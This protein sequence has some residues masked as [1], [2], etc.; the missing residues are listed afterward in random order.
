MANV[1]A[2]PNAIQTLADV[3]SRWGLQPSPDADFFTEWQQTLPTLTE[4]EQERLTLMARR[5]T[6]HRAYG[7]LLEGTV[8]LLV[9][10]PLL[11]LTGFYDPPFQLRAETTVEIAVNDGEET[12]R[13]RIDVLVLQDQLWLLV[14]ESKKTTIPVRSAL[15]QT[16]AYRMA[17][18]QPTMPLYGVL[19]NG[20]DVLFVKLHQQ[21]QPQYGLSRAFSLYTHQSE[22]VMTAQILK[23]LSRSVIGA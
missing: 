3:E 11:E 13:G 1:V 20:D 21:P 17:T 8:T 5:L 16:L 6:Y 15:P 7:E 12:L 9:A 19:T 2:V 22:L 10:A 4:R 23:Q 18:P 14:L